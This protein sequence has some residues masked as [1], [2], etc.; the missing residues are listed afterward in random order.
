[1]KHHTEAVQHSSVNPNWRTPA[2]LFSVLDQEFVFLLDAAA[3]KAHTLCPH[4]FG[5]D[6]RDPRYRDALTVDWAEYLRTQYQLSALAD[7]LPRG[8][9]F[10]N[11]P[12][13]RKLGMPIA[14]WIEKCWIESQAGCTIV[15]VIP[16]SPQTDWWRTWVEGHGTELKDFHA[17]RE[18][19]KIPHRVSFLREDGTEA[20]NAGGN[21]AIVVWRPKHGIV[22]PWMPWAPYWTYLD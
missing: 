4:Y 9:I 22:A 10:V 15:A 11:P 13:S 1:M 18:T 8:A 19:R 2:R 16:Y 12:Y 21:T 20:E 7:P 5:P 6:H 17:A 3:T 14:P